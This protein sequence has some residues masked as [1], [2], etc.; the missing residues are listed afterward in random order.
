M[1]ARACRNVAD[2]VAWAES[3][4]LFANPWPMHR[5][6]LLTCQAPSLCADGAQK[7][8]LV[9]RFDRKSKLRP[10]QPGFCPCLNMASARQR[11][12]HFVP[13]REKTDWSI[14]Q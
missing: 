11:R 10:R 4:F 6:C 1:R 8:P 9:P 5:R 13:N 3:K 7:L 2:C 12:Q 14:S